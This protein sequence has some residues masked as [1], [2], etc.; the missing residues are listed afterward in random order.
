MKKFIAVFRILF[1]DNLNYRAQAFVWILTSVVPTITSGAVWLAAIGNGQLGDFDRSN[2]ILYF[3]G[4]LALSNLV[5]SSIAWDMGMEIKQGK[6][7][8]YLVKPL[9]YPGYQFLYNL[10]WRIFRSLLF[11]PVLAVL[12]L[13]LNSY[14]NWG[15]LHLGLY[16]WMAVLLAHLLSFSISFFI[17]SW[18]L[19]LEDM[20]GI[21]EFF[22]MANW[23]LGGSI[24]PIALMPGVLRS[25]ALNAPFRYT[26]SYPIEV[27]LGQTPAD[28]S[29]FLVG[30]LWLGL[31]AI[32]G[33][34][35]WINGIKRYSAVGN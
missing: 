27:M 15:T 4:S 7:S 13:I 6:L 22:M 30:A 11:I 2:I 23:L 10:A 18:A 32:L 3:L 1:Q 16:F 17:G 21:S 9:S 34:L 8:L 14:V 33:A 25:F 35:V 20:M 28:I 19:F 31:F 5:T 24:A 26:L 12:V 29:H